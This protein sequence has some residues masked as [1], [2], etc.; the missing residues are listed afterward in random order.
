[1]K[2]GIV[3]TWDEKCGLATYS[4]NIVRNLP[5]VDWKILGR[6]TWGPNF[7]N[8]P[9]NVSDCDLVHIMHHGGLMASM[10]SEIVRTCGKTVITRQC[11]GDEGVFSAADIKTAHIYI[12]G[13]RWVPHGIHTID[14]IEELNDPPTIG[15]CGI[16][17]DGKG[18]M[19]VVEIAV[20]AGVG[21]NSV[22][23]D[24]PH[25]GQGMA[26]HIEAH[27]ARY[28][29]PCTIT[30]DWLPEEEVSKILSRNI[31]NVF[32]YTRQANGISGAIRMGLAATRPVIVNDHSQFADLITA[33]AVT[34]ASSCA[35]TAEMIKTNAEL[36]SSA[37]ILKAW[38]YAVIAEVYF[39][40]YKEVLGV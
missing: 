26:A 9:G 11:I 25:T 22:I 8:L 28:G 10:S 39:T 35:Q 31:I 15:C 30:T 3:T 1:M 14:E 29:V 4:E 32:F 6:E 34:V 36:A 23:P 33:G 27:C 13:Y 7:T 19:E 2:V 21:I 38:D 37:A 18:H 40:L 20:M 5:Q 12:P 24:N 16:P 17:F